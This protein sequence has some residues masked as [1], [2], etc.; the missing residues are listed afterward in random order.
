MPNNQNQTNTANLENFNSIVD[1]YCLSLKKYI[2]SSD[3]ER[4]ILEDYENFAWRQNPD[5]KSIFEY[6][7]ILPIK[8]IDVV[9]KEKLCLF[10]ITLHLK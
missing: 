10:I 1:Q 9:Y 5:L 8:K 7:P 6:P 2:V 3:N 4:V